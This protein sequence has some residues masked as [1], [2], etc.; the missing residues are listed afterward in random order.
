[1]SNRKPGNYQVIVTET[2]RYAAIVEARSR[3]H[4]EKLGANLWHEQMQL[5]RCV[6]DGGIEHIHIAKIGG[7]K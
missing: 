3:A 7:R 1:M 6:S 2:L 4:A 5:F